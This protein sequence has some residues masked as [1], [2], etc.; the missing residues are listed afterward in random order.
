[1]SRLLLLLATTALAGAWLRGPSQQLQVEGSAKAEHPLGDEEKLQRLQ[2]GL[3]SIQHLRSVFA[4][5]ASEGA[6]KF[7]TGA[8]S[9][10]LSRKD[11]RVWDVINNMIASTSKAAGQLKQSGGEEKTKVMASLENELNEKA[12]QLAGVTDTVHKTQQMEDEEYLLGLLNMHRNFS[13]AWQLNATETLA[14]GS[15]VVEE[16]LKHHDS[17]RP[18]AD[19]LAKLMDSRAEHQAVKLFLQLASSLQK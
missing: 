9:D 13:M 6:S 14:H 15:P 17:E 16:L 18:L 19:Q 2:Q 11:S 12:E 7:A 1:M 3:A 8:L 5:S 4:N 10:E